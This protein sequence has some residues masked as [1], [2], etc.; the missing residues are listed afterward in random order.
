MQECILRT[1]KQKLIGVEVAKLE[2]YLKLYMLIKL[3]KQEKK[4][5]KKYELTD[6]TIKHEG[7]ILHKIRA[8]RDFRDVKAGDLGGFVEG[9]R[10]LDHIGESW[11]YGNARVCGNAEVCGNAWVCDEARVSDE[12]RVYGNA[13]VSDE[14]RVYGNAWVDGEARVYGKARVHGNAW[15]S[16]EA[17]VYGDAWVDGSA[18]IDGDAD[19]SSSRDY[20]T[21]SNI[22]SRYGVTTFFK[23]Q[24]GCIGVTCGCFSGTLDEFIRAVE[25]THGNN[26]YG[27]IYRSAIKL[28]R[29]QILGEED[30]EA[31]S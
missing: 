5:E 22:G 12:A 18:E 10:N 3:K 16:D 27:K 26:E 19:I 4:M 25:K 6:I 31:K 13:W 20:I 2:V 17:R 11:V 30:N 21:I 24:N 15:V 23:T 9:E 29:L 28:A 1:L 7:G 8:L 14:A